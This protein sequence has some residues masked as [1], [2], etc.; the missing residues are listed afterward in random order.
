[1]PYPVARFTIICLLMA[2]SGR[3]VPLLDRSGGGGDAG[4]S[5]L[6]MAIAPLV[7]DTFLDVTPAAESTEIM[8][9]FEFHS[10]VADAEFECRV[11]STTFLPCYTP[12]Q[13]TLQHVGDHTFEVR[14]VAGG[15]TDPTPARFDWRLDSPYPDIAVIEA[16]DAWVQVGDEWRFGEGDAFYRFAAP[17]YDTWPDDFDF[18]IVWSDFAMRGQSFAAFEVNVKYDVA[19]IGF[20]QL[21][22]FGEDL[23]GLAGSAGRLQSLVYMNGKD[24]WSFRSQ[25]EVLDVV[26]QE[27]GHRWLAFI[28]LLW[29]SDPYLLLC[30][31]SRA[32]W[33]LFAGFD[34]P[35]PLGLNQQWTRQNADGTFTSEYFT[36]VAYTSFD[37]YAMGMLDPLDTPPF[38]FVRNPY[39]FSPPTDPFGNPWNPESYVFGSVDFS[40]ER[41][42][43]TLSDIVAALGPRDPEFG[44]AQTD[45]RQAF[46]L[47][48]PPGEPA[49]IDS[50]E[51]LDE[52]RLDWQDSFSD[53]TRGVGS[54]DTSLQ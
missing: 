35:S 13:Y 27:V 23:T 18:L 46:V 16:N 1:M 28:P 41:V 4:A 40:G 9:T 7:P 2:C 5:A 6:D 48:T 24:Y 38:F 44:R 17:F 15:A 50:L 19:G 3:A 14:A 34:A 30:P 51:W 33:N 39:A 29:E 22:V 52:M 53:M 11:D 10:D 32:H 8:P 21:G 49:S 20:E 47:V 43:V 45:F 37:L 12:R 54:V 42:D 31:S 25:Q 36:P 26:A